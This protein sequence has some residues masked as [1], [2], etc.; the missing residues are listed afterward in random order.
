IAGPSSFD[1]GPR[2]FT[3]NWQELRRVFLVQPGT[4]SVRA[5]VRA[6]GKGQ[7]ELA[8]VQFHAQPI[9]SYQTGALVRQLHPALRN[10]V[11]LESNVGIVNAAAVSKEDI[12]GDG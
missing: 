5:R 10:G 7:I 12:D 2:Y 9:D 3:T 8:D 6:S 4:A 11:V 1:G